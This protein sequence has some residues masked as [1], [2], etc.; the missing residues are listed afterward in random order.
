MIPTFWSQARRRTEPPRS[1]EGRTADCPRDDDTP[2]VIAARA[3]PRAF[4]A[5]YERHCDAVY[6]YC[7]VRLGSRELAEDATSETFLKALAGLATYRTTDHPG[8]REGSFVAWLFGIARN[9]VVDQHRRR[10][11]TSPIDAAG[12]P[13]DPGL[14]PEEQALARAEGERLRAAMRALT[15]EQRAVLD[16]QLAGLTG[17]EIARALGKSPGAVKML[18]FR[19]VERLREHLTEAE[20]RPEEV[21]DDRP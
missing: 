10:R 18:R 2:L 5:L 14:T 13:A 8:G 4:T 3:D 20:S 9:V 17:E 19:A 11:P 15:S 16:L 12:D 21:R 1:G 6:R 7:H